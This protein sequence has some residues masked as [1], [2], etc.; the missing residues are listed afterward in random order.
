MIYIL[1][2]TNG[3]KQFFSFFVKYEMKT[4]KELKIKD[5]SVY[6]F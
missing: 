6:F 5:W 3:Y 2:I 4:I 1:Y